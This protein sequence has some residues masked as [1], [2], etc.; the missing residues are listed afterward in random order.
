GVE[1][2]RDLADLFFFF[3]GFVT[4]V[5]GVG[6]GWACNDEDDIIRGASGL[7]LLA[8]VAGLDAYQRSRSRAI[9]KA[10]T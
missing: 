7:G 1:H 9:D 2:F 5:G 4:E 10:S 8:A 3:D 6:H